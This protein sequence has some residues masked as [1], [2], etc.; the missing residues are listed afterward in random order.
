LKPR[1]LTKAQAAHARTSNYYG[2]VVFHEFGEF[3]GDPVTRWLH[4]QGDGRSM[5]LVEDFAY[6]DPDE[7]LW[8]APA[9]SIVDGASIPWIFWRIIGA[10][11]TG[12]YRR[13]SVIHDVYCGAPHVRPSSQVHRMFYWA[14]RRG[15]VGRLKA[16]VMWLCVRFFGPSWD[17]EA[18]TQC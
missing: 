17:E 2:E 5:E 15:G 7:V 13:A 11:Y 14:C 9:G 8:T 4:D 6:I 10:P 3:R 1:K 12:L 16:Y 18:D